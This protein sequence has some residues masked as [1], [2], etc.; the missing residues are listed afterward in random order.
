MGVACQAPLSMEFFRQEYWS[1]LP[2]PSLGD[3][4]DPGLEPGSPTLQVASLPSEPPG[5]P[6]GTVEGCSFTRQ[7]Q[8]AFLI[9]IRLTKGWKKLGEAVGWLSGNCKGPE[10]YGAWL[11]PR[12]C[13]GWSTERKG[14]G[15]SEREPGA[16]ALWALKATLGALNFTVKSFEKR[17]HNLT[18]V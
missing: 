17:R 10:V 18:C 6:R 16:A 3:L 1:G 14:H 12:C 4:P 5:K 7:S 11:V 13:C 8:K 9:L 2:F 15:H